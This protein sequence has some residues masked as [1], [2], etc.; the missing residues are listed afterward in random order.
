M[1]AFIDLTGQQFG[2]LTVL[3]QVPN[4]TPKYG[5]TWLC[6]C[7]CGSQTTVRVTNLRN[8]RTRS[9]GCLRGKGGNRKHGKSST[10]AYRAW[11]NM[12]TRGTNPNYHRAHRYSKRGILVCS[13]WSTSF[14]DF[15]KDMGEP[16]GS[17]YSL[18]RINNDK[19]YEPRNCRWATRAEQANNTGYNRLLTHAG[20]TMTMA[21]A[22]RGY[23]IS[24]TTLRGRLRRGW[25]VGRALLET[26]RPLC[27]PLG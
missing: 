24:Y 17:G 6:H 2:L 26:V 16:P 27:K 20:E 21:Q 4:K 10:K 8:S 9:C 23:G 14:A 3:K 7:S 12:K 22:A 1:P 25:G 18:D 13:R 5:A 15:Y 19:G 11:S